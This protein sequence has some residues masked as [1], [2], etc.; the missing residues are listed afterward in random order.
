[1]SHLPICLYP[2]SSHC[3][4]WLPKLWYHFSVLQL[5]CWTFFDSIFLNFYVRWLLFS[6]Y[7][8]SKHTMGHFFKIGARCD[9]VLHLCPYCEFEMKNSNKSVV[10]LHLILPWYFKPFVGFFISFLYDKIIHNEIFVLYLD[11]VWDM[12]RVCVPDRNITTTT[13]LIIENQW[14][15]TSLIVR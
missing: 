3:S 14:I 15:C 5:D 1:M 12:N 6:G 4:L 13:E 11:F 10:Q 9:L 8:C 2:K 7:F